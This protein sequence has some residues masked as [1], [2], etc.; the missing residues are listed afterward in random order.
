MVLRAAAETSF[1]SVTRIC[2]FGVVLG[3]LSVDFDGLDAALGTFPPARACR[4]IPRNC[5]R[6]VHV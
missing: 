3:L 2:E 4:G 1:S 6:S 5:F